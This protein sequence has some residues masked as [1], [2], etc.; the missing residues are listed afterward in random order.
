MSPERVG[1]PTV[2]KEISLDYLDS[3]S[4]SLEVWVWNVRPA[5]DA[6]DFVSLGEQEFSKK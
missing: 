6:A 2:I 1:D 5:C 4:Q 3:T